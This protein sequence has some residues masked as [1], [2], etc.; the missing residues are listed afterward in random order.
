MMISFHG[1]IQVVKVQARRRLFKS[2]NELKPGAVLHEECH[3]AGCSGL[4]TP[5]PALGTPEHLYREGQD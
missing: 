3:C 2:V 5:S 4:G 1:N